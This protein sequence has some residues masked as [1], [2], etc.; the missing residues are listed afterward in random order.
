MSNKKKQLQK[1]TIKYRAKSQS[2]VKNAD[3]SIQR[4]ANSQ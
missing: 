3:K 4:Y 1:Q 2:L